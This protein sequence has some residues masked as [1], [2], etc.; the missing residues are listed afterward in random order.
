[1]SDTV[2]S[3]NVGTQAE[4]LEWLLTDR[5]ARQING[6]PDS[7]R[8]WADWKGLS[9]RTLRRWKSAP[10]FQARLKEREGERSRQ[11]RDSTVSALVAG[12]PDVAGPG[13]E[14]TKPEQDYET[15]RETIVR[16]AG[17]GDARALDLYMKY[18][19]KPFVDAELRDDDFSDLSD[20]ELIAQVLVAV[21]AASV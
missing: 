19:G 20:A 13:E 9:P 11:A 14:L 8:E 10:A 18:W 16:N 4:Y 7:D 6:L 21:G 5:R 3:A 17:K 12:V 1:M 2:V 15:V